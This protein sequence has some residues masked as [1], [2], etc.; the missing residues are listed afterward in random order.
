MFENRSGILVDV[1]NQMVPELLEIGIVNDI[2]V[3][4]LDQDTKPDF[5]T[6]GEWSGINVLINEG[7][8]FTSPATYDHLRDLT[9]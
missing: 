9:G 7:Q 3:A 1:T 4:D 6:V 8:R 5:I 2:V